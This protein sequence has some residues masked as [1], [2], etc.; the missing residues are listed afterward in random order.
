MPNI[1]SQKKRVIT[2]EKATARNKAVKSSLKT[3]L[4]KAQADI[5]SGESDSKAVVS[6]ASSAIDKAVK[7]GVIH[8]NT[9]ARK[10]AAIA[11]SANQA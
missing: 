4:K 6:A 1:K 5:A 9:A 7:K 10:K 3:A 11:R 2:N 8:K